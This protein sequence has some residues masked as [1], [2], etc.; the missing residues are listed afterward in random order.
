MAL[1]VAIQA[2]DPQIVI[3][4]A[5]GHAALERLYDISCKEAGLGTWACSVLI[6]NESPVSCT[7]DRIRIEDDVRIDGR[8]H[9]KY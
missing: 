1:Y 6:D 8:V 7:I 2:D 4:G 3:S 5:T 9:C